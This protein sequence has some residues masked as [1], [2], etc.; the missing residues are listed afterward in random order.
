VQY[1][2][3]DIDGV[4]VS[5]YVAAGLVTFEILQSPSLLGVNWSFD[6]LLVGGSGWGVS[7][8]LAISAAILLAVFASNRLD[9]SGKKNWWGMN[10]T[11]L[12]SFFGTL[13][14][15]VGIAFFA[16]LN[17]MVGSNLYVSYGGYFLSYMGLY[18]AGWAA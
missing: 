6:A 5:L 13:A 3:D 8:G 12:I 15:F 18:G 7:Y 17:N 10:E 11:E 16:P 14:I 2:L 9:Y 4:L 1:E